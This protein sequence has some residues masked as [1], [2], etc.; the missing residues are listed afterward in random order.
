VGG[1]L[2][3]LT[4]N[5]PNDNM[6]PYMITGVDDTNKSIPEQLKHRLIKLE[7]FAPLRS[8]EDF[9]ALLR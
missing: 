4:V 7:I 9:R 8:R 1:V 3:G 2:D 6:L 5:L